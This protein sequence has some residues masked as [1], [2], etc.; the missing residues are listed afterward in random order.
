SN[1]A[2]ACKPSSATVTSCPRRRSR[3][4]AR[5]W[6]TALSSAS[7][8]RSGRD[9]DPA[10]APGGGPSPGPLSGAWPFLDGAAVGVRTRDRDED[11]DADDDAGAGTAIGVESSTLVSALKRSDCVIGLV[12]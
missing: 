8:M 9:G 3:W 6:L 1:A 10:V 7:R 11:E 4:T 2:S 5:V 12:R